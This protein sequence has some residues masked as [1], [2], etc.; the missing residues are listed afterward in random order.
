MGNDL[1]YQQQRVKDLK[2]LQI[3]ILK[4]PQSEKTK[5]LQHEIIELSNQ[6]GLLPDDIS[7]KNLKACL[8][9]GWLPKNNQMRILP[10]YQSTCQVA[11]DQ[12]GQA[13][14]WDINSL[15]LLVDG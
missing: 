5:Q 10:P 15:H 13:G 7:T 11:V 8:N 9:P 1:V 3:E 6:Y 14:F 4:N 2:V 12:P